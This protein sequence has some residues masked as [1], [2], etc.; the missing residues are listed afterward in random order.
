MDHSQDLVKAEAEKAK[1]SGTSSYKLNLAD[2]VMMQMVGDFDNFLKTFTTSEKI[3]EKEKKNKIKQMIEK[4]RQE[5]TTPQLFPKIV[6]KTIQA[7]FGEKHATLRELGQ[8]GIDSYSPSDLIRRIAFNVEES[9]EEIVVKVRDFGSGMSLETLVRDLLIPY[10]SGKEFD[11]TK[12]GEHGIGWYSIVDLA[13]IVRV[14]TKKREQDKTIQALVYKE[15]GDWKT[16]IYPDSDQLLQTGKFNDVSE[17]Y[18]TEV[19]AHIPKSETNLDDIKS[20]LYQYLGRVNPMDGLITLNGEMINFMRAT[21]QLANPAHVKINGETENLVMG[22]SKR[23]IDNGTEDPRFKLRNR[24]LDKIIFT[25][26]GLFIKYDSNPFHT[27][28]IHA[29][30]LSNLSS[31]GLDFWIE[32]PENVTL[33]KGRNNIIADHHPAVLDASYQA[34]ENLFLDSILTDNHILNH[35]SNLVFST[36]ADIFEKSY[37]RTGAIVEQNEERKYGF[38]RKFM[39]RVSRF[40]SKTVDLASIV[41]EYGGK[42]AK[43][44]GKSFQSVGK[45]IFY[46]FPRFMFREVPKSLAEIMREARAERPS[47]DWNEKVANFKRNLGY[48]R[49]K[50]WDFT[51]QGVKLTSIA[52]G[53]SAGLAGVAYG[54]YKLY[55]TFGYKFPLYTAEGAAAIAIS[56]LALRGIKNSGITFGGVVRG[57]RDTLGDISDS[58]VH[59]LRAGKKES[60]D[61]KSRYD[62]SRGREY[63]KWGDIKDFFTKERHFP[64]FDLPD[65]GAIFSKFG[66]Y[67]DIEEKR[68]EKRRKKINKISKKYLSMMGQ[69]EFLKRIMHKEIIPAEFYTTGERRSTPRNRFGGAQPAPENDLGYTFKEFF[70]SLASP[71]PYYLSNPGLYDAYGNL[72]RA[73]VVEPQVKKPLLK[74]DVK[75]SI[76]DIVGI[77]LNGKLKKGEKYLMG[78]GEYWVDQKNPIVNSVVSKLES[79][80]TRV[81]ARYDVRILEDHIDNIIDGT[82]SLGRFTKQTAKS[83][84]KT[85]FYLSGIGPAMIVAS[86]YTDKIPNFYKDSTIDKLTF[87]TY[88]ACVKLPQ[89]IKAR[90]DEELELM[91][92]NRFEKKYSNPQKSFDG[93]FE[94]RLERISEMSSAIYGGLVKPVIKAVNPA[95]YPGYVVK[96]AKWGYSGLAYLAESTQ[97]IAENAKHRI[98]NR[99]EGYFTARKK[100]KENKIKE[101]QIRLE[102]RA[103]RMEEKK[104]REEAIKKIE[105]QYGIHL[106]FFESI[107]ARSHEFYKMIFRKSEYET[108]DDFGFYG[109]NKGKFEKIVEVSQT[110]TMYLN[111]ANIVERF[112]QIVSHVLD[113]KPRKIKISAETLKSIGN[114]RYHQPTASDD[115]YFAQGDIYLDLNQSR[116]QIA[117]CFTEIHGDP[118]TQYVITERKLS[119]A[120]TSGFCYRIIDDLIHQRVHEQLGLRE[121]GYCAGADPGSNHP[122]NFYDVK[123]EMTQKVVNYLDENKIDL[124]VIARPY[125]PSGEEFKVQESLKDLGTVVNFLRRRI[126]G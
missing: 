38:K 80:S 12:I 79:V 99:F 3:S 11:P 52:G 27:E 125:L 100:K 106:G 51:K 116:E 33:T 57:T 117:R 96:T 105:E 47:E 26:R 15:R 32:V 13:K 84:S 18:G 94:G 20:Y 107:K 102:L 2:L 112:D 70:K 63:S 5:V 42:G 87:G 114:S 58:F 104:L 45:G 14:T 6:D 119:E 86:R 124:E 81:A 71:D 4:T 90:I 34:F 73:Q 59:W 19:E 85:A 43:V 83:L 16:T 108:S 7:Q 110:G 41:A 97:M 40:G 31:M 72:R 44:V 123:S 37:E 62:Y 50:T 89:K 91:A 67:K 29:N 88:N 111:Y 76:D 98:E 49:E 122:A 28:S 21:Y 53:I 65:R 48:L 17:D 115:I 109:I 75:L 120:K 1:L 74:K 69:N 30:L 25:Q 22:F 118:K 103:S 23:E 61:T 95:A 35:S 121:H 68:E 39:S 8:N 46:D 56:Y 64:E 92:K 101:K 10:N 93:K 66:L 113:A 54:S 36:I 9:P 77:F 24:N 82:L 55:Q 126:A 78:D 60:T